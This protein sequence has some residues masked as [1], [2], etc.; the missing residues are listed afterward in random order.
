M[1][2]RDKVNL[3]DGCW[4]HL[5]AVTDEDRSNN[6]IS[7]GPSWFIKNGLVEGFGRGLMLESVTLEKIEPTKPT[8]FQVFPKRPKIRVELEL[9]KP[10]SAGNLPDGLW[11]C[12]E[13]SISHLIFEGKFVMSGTCELVKQEVAT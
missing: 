1:K 2:I 12:S 6:V 4:R 9:C 11:G 10:L 5:G 7:Y 13:L 8:E 3:P